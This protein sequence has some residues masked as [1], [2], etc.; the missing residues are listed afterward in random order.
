MPLP[1][2]FTIPPSNRHEFILPDEDPSAPPT[3]KSLNKLITAKIAESP[4]CVEF[5]AHHKPAS[6]PK[7]TIQQLRMHWDTKG[8]DAKMWPE[9]TILTDENLPAV[10]E[11]LRRCVVGGVLEVG[12]GSA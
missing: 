6:A 12:L 10:L 9:Y 2:L 5:M 11:V 4:N 8:R 7:E 1:I 3:L